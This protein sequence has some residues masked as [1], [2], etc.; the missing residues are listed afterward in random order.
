MGNHMAV[1]EA[2]LSGRVMPGT[3]KD[4]R[5]TLRVFMLGFSQGDDRPEGK[6]EVRLTTPSLIDLDLQDDD[7][8][9]IRGKSSY[10]PGNGT[11]RGFFSI[12]A[13]TV[14]QYEERPAKST[15]PSRSE[16]PRARAAQQNRDVGDIPF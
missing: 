3:L 4:I 11:G 10:S 15:R 1:N 5:P 6:V 8:V 7:A 9:I 14:E 16:N 2:A 12:D 13:V